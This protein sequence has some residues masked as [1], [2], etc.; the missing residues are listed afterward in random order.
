MSPVHEDHYNHNN[1]QFWIGLFLGGLIGALLI[2]VLGTEK[3]RK[4]AK[5]LQEEGLDLW[6]E[7]KDEFNDKKKAVTQEVVKQVEQLEE[8]GAELIEKGKELIEEG[9]HIEKQVV[10]EVVET[11]EELAHQVVVQAD[12]ALAHIEQLQER[13]RQTTAELRKRLFK[14]IPKKT[15]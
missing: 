12:Q 9:R 7:K 2:V 14:N 1:N 15:S 11:K 10:Q 3:G 6:E 8:K 5:K 4:L 13:G